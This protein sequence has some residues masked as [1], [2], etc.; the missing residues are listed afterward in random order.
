MKKQSSKKIVETEE[1]VNCIYFIKT[2]K[3]KKTGKQHIIVGKKNCI[4][5]NGRYNISKCL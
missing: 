1:L 2:R 5:M 4:F 3:S